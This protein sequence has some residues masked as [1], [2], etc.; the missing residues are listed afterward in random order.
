MVEA[1]IGATFLDANY[2]G[3]LYGV[4]N[5]EVTAARAAY[6]PGGNWTPRVE[7]SALYPVSQN[8][9]VAGFFEHAILP[10]AISDSPLVGVDERTTIGLT[11]IRK[12]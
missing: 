2:A 9:A 6:A 11:W 3:Y 8:T 1:S 5:G 4:A 7:V 10:D 12:F